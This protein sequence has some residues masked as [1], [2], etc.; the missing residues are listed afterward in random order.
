MDESSTYL[1][2]AIGLF[3]IWRENIQ[4]FFETLLSS[5]T[6]VVNEI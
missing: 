5:E 6:E 2:S 3:I 4:N 1:E